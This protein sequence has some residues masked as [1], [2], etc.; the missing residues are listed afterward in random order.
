MST[1]HIFAGETRL[2]SKTDAIYMQAPAI[3]Y[4]H[5]DN[6]G[7][8]S[9]T[10]AWSQDPTKGNQDLLQ[11]ERY[12][13]F[14]ELWRPGAEQEE[15][16][17]GRPDNLRREYLFTGKEWDVDESLY[18]FGARYFDPHADVWQSP[19]PILA[20]YVRGQGYGGVYTP[21]NLS[22]YSYSRNNPVVLRDPD[23]RIAPLIAAA[24]AI[25]VGSGASAG[26]RAIQNVSSGQPA[27]NGVL[28]AAAGTAVSGSLT[29]ASGGTSLG[30]QLFAGALANPIG[31]A[32]SRY[33]ETGDPQVTIANVAMDASW[34]VI[35]GAIAHVAA[36]ADYVSLPTTIEAPAHP[37]FEPGPYAS[38]SIPA[39][40]SSQTFAASERSQVNAF[41]EES[42]CHT[43]GAPS[44]GTK[45]GNWVLDHQPVTSLAAPG[46]PQRLYPQCLGC[47]K[48]QGLAAAAQARKR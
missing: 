7:T 17:Q 45:S 1:K 27:G 22:L 15:T 47:S 12:F 14:G 2:V 44:P 40:S 20:S 26:I 35:G 23:G 33:V 38:G 6:L 28:G 30:T 3:S 4:Y 24:I 37:T 9:Y 8:T 46:A 25:L 13:A 31:G 18:Y 32:V 16:D 5:D 42:G 36:P 19:D 48:N 11:H 34:G 29:L 39:R 41:G 10:S 21:S 43:C